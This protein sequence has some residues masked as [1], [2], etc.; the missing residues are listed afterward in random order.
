MRA[1]VHRIAAML[2]TLGSIIA[3]ALAGG[4]GFRGW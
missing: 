3:L 1:T 4:A 2:A